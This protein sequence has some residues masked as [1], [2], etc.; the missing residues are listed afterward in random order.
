VIPVGSIVGVIFAI[1]DASGTTTWLTYLAL[2]A[3]PI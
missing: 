2:V 1:R 3:V